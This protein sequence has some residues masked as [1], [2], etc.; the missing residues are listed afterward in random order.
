MANPANGFISGCACCHSNHRPQSLP[1]R[2]PLARL[3]VAVGLA[4]QRGGEVVRPELDRIEREAGALE[5]L[6]A[7]LLSVARLEAEETDLAGEDVAI[8]ELLEAIVRD[9]NY[10]ATAGKTLVRVIGKSQA[11]VRGYRTLLKS[12]LENV[13]RNA[14]THTN[15]GTAVEITVALVEPG[16]S[17]K[18]AVRDYGA[19]V[20]EELL[21]EIFKPSVRGDYA[22]DRQS[23]GYGIG[24]AITEA[25][26]VRHGG[27][28][29][30]GNHSE[31][32]LCV[33]TELPCAASQLD[34]NT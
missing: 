15:N 29:R 11:V 28:I 8:D 13:V 33:T 17:V 27:T 23:G 30:A 34:L 21:S 16:D 2:S 31:G 26:I 6:I 3:Q 20:T 24:L 18:I 4:Y 10:E 7:Q 9:A 1:I 32:G 22:R 12:A 19:G 5:H 25:A 14:I